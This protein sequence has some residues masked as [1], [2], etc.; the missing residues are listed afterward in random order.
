MKIYTPNGAELHLSPSPCGS[1]HLHGK[2]NAKDW[3]IYGNNVQVICD[4]N[5]EVQQIIFL[6]GKCPESILK[7]DSTTQTPV[8]SKQQGSQPRS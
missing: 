1:L 4:E 3:G 7:S 8:E 6:E 5:G 2:S